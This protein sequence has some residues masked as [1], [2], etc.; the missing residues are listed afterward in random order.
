MSNNKIFERPSENN[1]YIN[2]A[3]VKSSLTT[4]QRVLVWCVVFGCI[5]VVLALW[6][7]KM[8]PTPYVESEASAFG[9]LGLHVHT[10]ISSFETFVISASTHEHYTSDRK[11]IKV[12]L[13]S[14]VPHDRAVV[15]DFTQ[16][17][18][19]ARSFRNIIN[20]R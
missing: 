13:P 5:E 20:W 18:H 2:L 16:H 19:T 1:N 8:L 3:T 12:Y 17:C 10:L 9:S 6:K 15:L 7:K 14:A 11:L 4:D